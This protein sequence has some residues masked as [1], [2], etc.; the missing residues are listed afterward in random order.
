MIYCLSVLALTLN[1][2]VWKAFYRN[3]LFL[4]TQALRFAAGLLILFCIS[5]FGLVDHTFQAFVSYGTFLWGIFLML[6]LVYLHVRFSYFAGLI[7]FLS[8]LIFFYLHF[9]YPLTITKAKFDFVEA[10]TK[11]VSYKNLSMDEKHIPVVPEKYARYKSEKVLGE[12]THVS[13]YQLGRT[14]LQKIGGRLCWVTPVEYLG[15]F[16]WMKSHEV[17]GYIKVNA[18]DENGAAVLVKSKMKYVPSAYFDENLKRAVRNVFKSDILF[19]PSFEPDDN[20]KPYYVVPYGGYTKFRQIADIKGVLLVDPKDGSMKRYTLKNLPSFID[21]AVPSAVAEEWNIWY[22]ENVHGFWNKLFSQDDVKK[23]TVWTDSD[24]VNGVFDNRLHLNWFHDFTR[25]KS[26]SGAMVGYSLL[27][28]RTGRMTYYNDVSGLLNGKSAMNVAEKTFKQNK[29]QAG[30]PNLYTIYNQPTWVVPLMDAN[31][32][33]REIMLVNAGNENVYSAEINKPALFDN[34]KYAL[35]TKLGDDGIASNHPSQVKAL[36]GAVTHVYQFQ[37][38]QS[39]QTI[40]E[41]M[42]KGS[43]K[44]FEVSSKNNPYT[45]FIKEG[46]AVSIEYIDT[47]ET[48]SSVKVFKFKSQK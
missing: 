41:F 5:Y 38:A 45:V 26:G 19:S 42:I 17:P 18:E 13:Y 22:G 27:N 47:Q 15:F 4:W 34:Y 10:R 8:I 28:T 16:K 35:A 21:Q 6:D 32:V 14:S 31:D 1:P 12:L 43:K 40:S 2:L 24:E 29:Y 25:P 9:L 23:P 30:I 44:I 48:V 11:V 39:R 33:L 37:D 7:G 20:G 36:A 3:S 46:D